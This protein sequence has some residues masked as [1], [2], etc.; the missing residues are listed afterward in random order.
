MPCQHIM[1]SG[2]RKGQN[3]GKSNWNVDYCEVNYCFD[4]YEKYRDVWEP[5]VARKQAEKFEQ[6]TEER[7]KFED[8]LEP[9][10][11]DYKWVIANS[12]E[13]FNFM[14]Q[15]A[16]KTE[17][18]IIEAVDKIILDG[19]S[20]HRMMDGTY[21][22]ILGF[23]LWKIHR[24]GWSDDEIMAEFEKRGYRSTVVKGSTQGEYIHVKS[25]YYE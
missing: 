6:Q 14:D 20:A 1:K 25:V 12:R 2:P 16:E 11:M 23:K 21:F 4:H 15:P 24:R 9:R 8:K 3:C 18:T 7:K 19:I 13:H 17:D 5:L 22:T 10:L